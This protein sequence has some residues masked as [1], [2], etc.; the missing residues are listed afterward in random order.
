MLQNDCPPWGKILTSPP[1]WGINIGHFGACWG[2]YTLFTEMPTYLKDIL[3]F[4]I[5]HVSYS[6]L[7]SIRARIAFYGLY[8]CSSF[9]QSMVLSKPSSRIQVSSA[10][11]PQILM[12]PLSSL[13]YL[14]GSDEDLGLIFIVFFFFTKHRRN[15]ERSLYPYILFRWDFWLR[16]HTC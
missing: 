12:A 16:V 2:Y 3:H 1:V 15:F 8:Y 4:D 11:M 14:L 9:D 10:A 6:S 13:I 5:K 7:I